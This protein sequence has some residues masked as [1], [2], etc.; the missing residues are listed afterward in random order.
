MISLQGPPPSRFA[1]HLPHNG[2]GLEIVA[3]LNPP[4]LWGRWIAKRDGRGDFQQAP[5]FTMIFRIITATFL[6]AFL[7]ATA[8]AGEL[9]REK[10]SEIFPAPMEVG[11]KDASFPVWPLFNGGGTDLIAWV[12]ETTELAPIPGFSGTPPNLLVALTP[13]GTF[14]DVRIISHHEPIFLDG[15]GPEP[16]Y[17]YVEQYRGKALGRPIKVGSNINSAEKSS[18]GAVYVDGVLKATASVLIINQTILASAIKVAKAKLGIAGASTNST[19]AKPNL[20]TYEKLSWQQLLDKGLV[21]HIQVTNAEIDKLYAGSIVEGQDEFS[22]KNPNQNFVDLYVADPLVPSAGRNLLSEASYKKLVSDLPD[23]QPAILLI[24]AGRWSVQGEEWTPGSVPDRVVFLQSG[25]PIVVRDMAFSKTLPLEGVPSQE[26]M[27][28][29]IPATAGFDPASPFDVV[30]HITRAKGI[31]LPELV[32]IDVPN[33]VQWPTDYYVVEK[34]EAS[35]EGWRAIWVQRKLDLAIVC[36]ALMLLSLALAFQKQL[37][38]NKTFLYLF[39]MGFLAFTL[40]FIGWYAQAQLSVVTLAGLVK[41]AAQ[42]HDFTF[43]LWDPPSLVLW[44][45]TIITFVLWGRGVFCG[46]LC[47]FGAMQEFVG[48]ISKHFH[49]PQLRI[50]DD[51]DRHLRKLKYVSLA[52]ILLAAFSPTSM[53]EKFAEVEPFKTSITLIFVR[54]WPFVA[55]AVSLL[56]IN[57]FVYKAFCRYLCPLGAMMAIGGKLRMNDWIPRRIEC[58]SPCQLCKVKCRYGAIEKSGAI[59]YDECF[60]CLDCVQIYED[61]KTCV[62]LVLE[63]R[64]N[65]KTLI[66]GRA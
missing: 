58:G 40:G 57:L 36:S 42:T 45:F 25:L 20:E 31:L 47:P 27:I 21:K 34:N 37:T 65:V 52:M 53:V 49:I 7:T 22:L 17:K 24:S 61:P 62:P 51:L 4:P 13:D 55:Y 30:P 38:K 44:I 6:L 29:K 54:Y 56:V 19:P 50:S 9:T 8:F 39:R 28:L 10:L 41:A 11:E 14:L 18:S 32:S 15:L 59:K 23:G 48:E 3:P 33:K 43:L 64:R 1:I 5:I 12:F 63:N 16:L 35:I 2:G 26:V 60:Q 66:G 46:W